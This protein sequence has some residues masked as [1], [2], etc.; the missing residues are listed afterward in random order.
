[1]SHVFQR[2]M[3]KPYPVAVAGDGPYIIDR[4][5]R[6]YLDAASGAGVS[7]LGYSDAAVADAIARQ[8]RQLAYVYNAY[9]TTEPA[10]QLAQALVE[11]TPAGLDWVFFGSGGSESMD[12]A[13]KMALQFHIDNGQPSRR[14]F[15][16]RRQSYHGCAM[17]GLAVSGNVIRRML[18]EDVLMP[19]EF[20]SP[21]YAYREQRAGESDADYVRRLALE[22]EQTILRVGPHT[23]AAFVAEPVVGATNGAV[24]ALPGYFKAVKAVLDRYGILLIADEILTGSGRTGTYLSIEQDGVTPDL[25]TLAKGLGAGY[26]PIS[27]ILVSGRIFDTLADRRGYFIHGHTYNASATPCAA[28]LAVI[29]QIR[30]RGLL[31]R[32]QVQGAR[33]R[34]ALAQRLGAHPHVGDIRGRGLLLGLELVRD[35]ETKSTFDPTRMLWAGVQQQAMQRGLICYPMGGTADGMNG[36]HILLAPPFIIDD[37]HIEEIVDKLAQS[38]DAAVATLPAE[39]RR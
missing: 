1:M 34:G 20:V 36:D 37:G 12:G 19:A 18:F 6:R 5:G 15:I 2:Y 25:V 39:A 29:T 8:A 35:R 24:P 10:E 22:L 27:A 17:G 3:R 14:R 32:V 4:D 23:V 21:C 11:M 38:I 30:E 31:E 33:L 7:S 13:L 16:A 28:A 26:L 9:F